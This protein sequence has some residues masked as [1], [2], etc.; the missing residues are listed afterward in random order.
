MPFDP[1]LPVAN[2]PL[3]SA[4]MRAQLTALKAPIEAQGNV[5]YGRLGSDWTSG[6]S[7]FSDV[8]GLS[9]SVASGE[10]WTAE[11]VLHAVSSSS[12][13]GFKFRVAG[14]GAGSVL[15]AIAGQKSGTQFF[16]FARMIAAHLPGPHARNS[17]SRRRTLFHRRI[18]WRR[19]FDRG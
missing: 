8:P 17:R 15:I 16:V 19:R 14:S 13:Q 11:I 9:F 5:A 18:L 2:S 4:E 3:S 10:N 1:T 7:S 12:G 6:T